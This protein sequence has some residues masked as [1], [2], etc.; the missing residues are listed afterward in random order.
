MVDNGGHRLAVYVTPGTRPAVVLDS[1][2]GEDHTEWKDIVP[3]LHAAT[4]SEII[5]YDRAGM[6][7]SDEVPG[8]WKVQNAVSD[9]EAILRQLGVTKAV[10][11]SH[12]QAGEIATY[13]A[14]KHP[15]VVTGAVLVDASLPQFYTDAEIRLPPDDLQLRA[16]AWL[17][18]TAS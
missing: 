6:G 2:G 17:D 13:F 8:P 10:L 11:V 5:T 15:K 12:S 3:K 1:G 9:M 18:R 7:A 14:R 16:G 4:G